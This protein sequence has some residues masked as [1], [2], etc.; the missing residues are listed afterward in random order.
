MHSLDKILGIEFPLMLAPMFLVTNSKMVK[1]ALDNGI[2]A[3]MPAMNFRKTDDLS[4][5]IRE[6][7][8]YTDK[9]FGI[10]LI[11]NKSNTAYKKQLFAIL[12]N[13]PAF[14]ISSLGNPK[15]LIAEA[16]KLGI[17]VFCDVVDLKYAKKVEDVGADALI[18]V[19]SLAGGHCGIYSPEI[20]IPE[21]VQNCNIP[22][23]SAGGISKPGDLNRIMALGAIGASVGTIFIASEECPVS[24]EYKNALIKFGR[25][26]IVLT[27]KLSGA[28]TT[29][30]NTDYVKKIGT[31]PGFLE[32]LILK[33]SFLKKTAKSILTKTGMNKLQKSAFKASYKTFWCAGPSIEDITSIRPMSEIIEEILQD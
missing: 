29:V 28:P 12:D 11:T 20:L 23:I 2:S 15:E 4:F 14:V 21:L 5:A 8:N 13:A 3:A 18:A 30:I 16:H 24:I 26:D 1:T 17:K 9:P 33:N 6:I 31:K 7:K 32:M 25:N 27:R 22:V 19:N 10:N